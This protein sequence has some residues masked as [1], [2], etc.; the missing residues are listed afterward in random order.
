VRFRDCHAQEKLED[1]ELLPFAQVF[2]GEAVLA[3]KEPVRHVVLMHTLS[4]VQYQAADSV[5]CCQPSV[6][7][8]VI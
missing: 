6:L 7:C 4:G 1:A 8:T 5:A 2:L 3:T